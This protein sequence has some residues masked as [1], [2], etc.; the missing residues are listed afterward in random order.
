M[1]KALQL[2]LGDLTLLILSKLVLGCDLAVE[3]AG[4]ED[5]EN[6]VEDDQESQKSN[7]CVKQEHR[8]KE[9]CPDD[10]RDD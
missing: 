3:S 9:Q 2:S 4:V 7:S 8:T 10:H 5:L 1:D 6:D